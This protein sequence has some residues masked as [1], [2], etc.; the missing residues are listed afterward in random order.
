MESQGHGLLGYGPGSDPSPTEP[1]PMSF[2]Q[3]RRESTE[4]VGTIPPPADCECS[5]SLCKYV[6]CFGTDPYPKTD[7]PAATPLEW[8]G[9]HR[10]PASRRGPRWLVCRPTQ[11]LE[12]PLLLV[13]VAE[14]EWRWTALQ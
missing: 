8:V 10:Q 1:K 4:V 5:D 11:S 6:V 9:W 12:V 3:I 13:V 2:L 7:S 14:V